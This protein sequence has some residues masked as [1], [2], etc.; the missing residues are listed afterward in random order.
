MPAPKHLAAEFGQVVDQMPIA[1]IVVDPVTRR[2]AIGHRRD[3]DHQSSFRFSSDLRHAIPSGR[4]R[5]QALS[6]TTLVSPWNPIC[7]IS[8]ARG[9]I[10]KRHVVGHRSARL[11]N[12]RLKVGIQWART[13]VQENTFGARAFGENY[14]FEQ[15]VWKCPRTAPI[16][17]LASTAYYDQ[18]EVTGQKQRA[19]PKK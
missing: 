10:S 1:R 15:R 19:E 7:R 11:M 17:K 16:Q 4:R 14:P 9:A 3:A 6:A 12:Q 5:P 8:L 13:V 2:I 18:I